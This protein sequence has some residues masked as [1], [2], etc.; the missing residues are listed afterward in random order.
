MTAPLKKQVDTIDQR[1]PTGFNNIIRDADGAPTG[2]AVCGNNEHACLIK[3]RKQLFYFIRQSD[4]AIEMI[5]ARIEKHVYRLSIFI[6]T[7]QKA[8]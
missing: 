4:D 6:L 7:I 2:F 5:T 3:T 8:W 1:E